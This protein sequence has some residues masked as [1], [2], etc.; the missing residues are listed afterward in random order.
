M[1]TH[2]TIGG[3]IAHSCTKTLGF[4]FDDLATQGC[5]LIYQNKR[6]GLIVETECSLICKVCPVCGHKLE[7]EPHAH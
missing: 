3:L 5:Y 2:K 7:E 1:P 4:H 6:W